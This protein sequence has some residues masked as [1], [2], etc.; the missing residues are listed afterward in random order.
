MSALILDVQIVSQGFDS[1]ITPQYYALKSSF[2]R[3]RS[4]G[5]INGSRHAIDD[6]NILINETLIYC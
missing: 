6:K 5:T 2:L 4:T 1:P 3:Y